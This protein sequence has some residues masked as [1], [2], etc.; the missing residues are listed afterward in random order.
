MLPRDI[1]KIRINSI[2]PLCKNPMSLK[3]DDINS[4]NELICPK[5]GVKIS[6]KH[7]ASDKAIEMIDKLKNQ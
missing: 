4:E 6:I 7:G 5:C 1:S 2:C 3:F